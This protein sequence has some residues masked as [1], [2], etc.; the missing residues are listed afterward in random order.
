LQHRAPWVHHGDP[1]SIP[2]GAILEGETPIE[3]AVRETLEETGSL[4]EGFVV[5]RVDVDDHGNW[6]YR[7]VL[8]D[9][10][11]RTLT[12]DTEEQHGTAWFTPDEM[13][14]LGLHP[15]FAAYLSRFGYDVVR[16]RSQPPC[17]RVGS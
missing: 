13:A 2:G 12:G 4:P 5:D 11:E 3:A 8:A 9:V 6:A 7:T 10:P 14:G 16:R 1:W 15:G 17:C